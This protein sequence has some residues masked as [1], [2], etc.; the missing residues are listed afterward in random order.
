MVEIWK[1]IN[2]FDKYEVSNFGNVRSY[3][4]HGFG[5]YRNDEPKLLNPCNV[6]SGYLSVNLCSDKMYSR[7]IHRL[8]AQAF[9]P[10]PNNLPQVNHIDGNK[11]N[12]KV[13]NLE[14]C[15]AQE[16]MKHAK[17]TG[18]LGEVWNKGKTDVY[19]KETLKKM[20]ENKKGIIT[21]RAKKVIQCDM[22]GNPIREW[23]SMSQAEKETGICH[24]KISMCCRG[25]KYKQT[26][27]YKWKYS[28]IGA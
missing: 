5:D 17:L 12:N 18:L 25:K 19:S 20:S 2:N 7:L 23:D 21:A 14:W 22:S 3:N 10:N 26:G 27:G 6:G 28:E 16:N 8:V 13:D 4:R 9:L 24:R 15:T 11:K 1:L